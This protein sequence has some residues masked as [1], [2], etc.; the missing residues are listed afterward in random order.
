MKYSI[1]ID[2]GGTNTR[3]ALIDD[4]YNI[5]DRVQFATDVNDPFNTLNELARY[6]KA[7]D[8]DLVGIGMSCPG[9]LDLVNN[10]IKEPPNLGV[11]W[12][13]LYVAKEL[14]KLCGVDVKL[15]NDANLAA[16]AEAVVG[17]GKEHNYVQFLTISTGVGA[18]L[19][20]NKNI[21][22]GSHGYANEVAN[23]VLK[24]D[25]P[26][27]GSI[28]PGGVEAIC[29]GTAIVMRAKA[30]GL[31]VDH[32]GNV[33]DLAAQGNIVAKDIMDDA[34]LYL[35]NFIAFIQAYADPDIII[36]GGSV[37][38]KIDGFVEEVAKLVDERVYD[39][40][41]PLVKIVKSDLNENS[42]LIGAAIL[43]YNSNL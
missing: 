5:L 30:N 29:S 12:H 21:F 15:Q 10:M 42:G 26:S 19:I 13:N 8:Y 38:T 17:Q 40:V 36:L 24:K 41:R 35:A 27:H 4:K 18:G 34:K 16:L 11:K 33:N 3:I 28:F 37:A 9:P 20:I 2:I 25:G 23:C 22:V 31:D 14:S 1:G 6:I 32:A 39:V 7:V 43:A